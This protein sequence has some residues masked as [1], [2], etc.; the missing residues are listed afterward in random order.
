LVP[1]GE[2]GK[3]GNG[4]NKGLLQLNILYQIKWSFEKEFIQAISNDW[5]TS[6]YPRASRKPIIVLTISV[7]VFMLQSG[8]I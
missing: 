4:D 6:A 2:V 8:Q 3:Y 5:K 7:L 1:T